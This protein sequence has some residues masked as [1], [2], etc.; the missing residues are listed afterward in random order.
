MGEERIK[1][2]LDP[3]VDQE[4]H[5]M[6]V[7]EHVVE[8]CELGF[9]FVQQVADQTANGSLEGLLDWVKVCVT[10]E[11]EVELH[12]LDRELLSAIGLF[13]REP[14]Q[15]GGSVGPARMAHGLFNH[16]SACSREIDD[17]GGPSQSISWRQGLAPYMSVQA[18]YD[19]HS[20]LERWSVEVGKREARE[21]L[22]AMPYKTVTS[23]CFSKWWLDSKRQDWWST[24]RGALKQ[25]LGYTPPRHQI[26][27]SRTGS[28]K[29]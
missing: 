15:E 26:R 29:F 4:P 25:A 19:G 5:Q 12:M 22:A 20:H 13:F 8:W 6:F 23:Y 18:M 14:A 16:A 28:M 27:D 7:Q 11:S 17:R 2:D 9:G 24:S 3:H 1:S 10:N 21:R